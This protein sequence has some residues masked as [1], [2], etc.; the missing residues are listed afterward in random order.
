MQR[1]MV[2]ALLGF[3]LGAPSMLA[4]EY[5]NHVEVGAFAEYFNLSRTSP[6]I[7]FRGCGRSRGV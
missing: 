2:L 1:S 7:N 3:L 6:H 4:Q 5:T